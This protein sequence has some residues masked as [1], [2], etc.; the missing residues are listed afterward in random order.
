MASPIRDS[1]QAAQIIIDSAERFIR[2]VGPEHQRQIEDTDVKDVV[3]ALVVVQQDLL[4]RRANRN[5]RKLHPFIQAL[6]HYS[7]ALDVL[8][9]G[10]SPFMPFIYAPIKLMLQIGSDYLAAFDK[11]LEAY[12]RIAATLPR[13]KDLGE[14]F[15]DS[16]TLLP[17]LA[18]YYA[19]V[20]EFHRRAYK[21]VTRKSWTFF[22]MTTWASFH[23]RFESILASMARNSDSIHQEAIVIDLIQSKKSRE[24]IFD[25]VTSQERERINK[26]RDS[27][28][29]WLGVQSPS[30]CIH[31]E[32]VLRDYLPGSCDW[33]IKHAKVIPW[34]QM[35]PKSPVLWIH[36]KP[37]AGKTVICA[38]IIEHLQA[39]GNRM[40]TV[41]YFC[42]YN[43]VDTSSEILKA[44]V[45]QLMKANPDMAAVIYDSYVQK[46]R[47]PSTRVLKMML[48]GAPDHPGL[49]S[50]ASPCRIII[51]GVDECASQEQKFIIQDMLQLVSVDSSQ[52][53]KVLVCSRDIPEIA[54]IM[55]NGAKKLATISL[56]DESDAISHTIESFA[57]PKLQ[58]LV[59]ERQTWQLSEEENS[60]L[61]K[62]VASR[63]GGMM[64]W[65]RLV[66]ESL[67]EVDTLRE[68]HD[69]IKTMPREL[70]DLYDKILTSIAEQ[71]GKRVADRILRILGWLVYAKRPLKAHEILHG[72]ALTV[73]SPVLGTWDMLDD[74]AVERCK[75]LIELLPDGSIGLI[76][77]TTE[78]YLRKRL[79]LDPTNGQVLNRSIALSCLLAL[80][81]GLD[82][83]DP[84]IPEEHRLHSVVSGSNAFLLYAVDFWL[85]HLLA[86]EYTTHIRASD[87]V[88]IVLARL[89][90]KHRS[91]WT[92][93]RSGTE[94]TM[95]PS[96]ASAVEPCLMVVSNTL[97]FPLCASFHEFRVRI[98]K[99]RASNGE[100]FEQL[101]LKEDSTLFTSLATTFSSLVARL[102]EGVLL[103]NVSPAQYAR[104]LKQYSQCSY[105]C[106]FSPCTRALA[107][108]PSEALRTTH[109]ELHARQLFCVHQNCA[110]GRIGF[111]NQR[112]LDA[113]TKKYHE[114]GGI[115]VP[116]RVRKAPSDI[117]RTTPRKTDLNPMPTSSITKV[118]VV[119][120]NPKCQEIITPFGE[121]T[122]NQVLESIQQASSGSVDSAVIYNADML[123]VGTFDHMLTFKWDAVIFAV[124]ISP[125]VSV[126]AFGSKNT[127][128]IFDFNTGEI[129]YR[130]SLDADDGRDNYV[131]SVK[132]SPDG[133]LLAFAG[134]DGSQVRAWDYGS[135]TVKTGSGHKGDILGLCYAPNGQFIATASG[136][137]TLRL[138]REEPHNATLTLQWTIT[139]LAGLTCV[140]VSPDSE[141][142]IVGGFDKQCRVYNAQTG[143]LEFCTPPAHGSIYGVAVSMNRKLLAT[144]SLDSKVYLFEPELNW[145]SL[146]SSTQPGIPNMKSLEYHV[147]SYI[148]L[149]PIHRMLPLIARQR[150]LYRIPCLILYLIKMIDGYSP[151]GATGL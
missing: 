34:V 37:G 79:Q 98:K 101:A 40:T 110:R 68:L 105:P 3:D 12:D 90:Q 125:D 16:P 4:R 62:K 9:N 72:V 24:Q 100:E 135:D 147:A 120:S 95:T 21:F 53:C 73:E 92:K 124:D 54:R 74:S 13:I 39:F 10:L 118:P 44:F 5:L 149:L 36:G 102:V 88:G 97:A 131:M 14:A 142:V 20:L 6:G 18:L 26:Q 2:T 126:V 56:S 144:S 45:L 106:R 111:Q 103:D 1:A 112:G 60:A 99:G 57:K 89:D 109:E 15:K 55:Q 22:F 139:E 35:Q 132:F 117:G 28:I 93:V 85:E 114:E 33:A 52:N 58:E 81:N 134:E 64:L 136:D 43:Q 108:F 75:P 46:H 47:E 107:G 51:D 11:L 41:Y 127:V 115:L 69:A 27:V 146:E 8:S 71:K 116:P 77:F 123:R 63:A 104:F 65:V 148:T 42:R 113:H 121:T 140:T 143:A 66:L 122:S 129:R 130:Y 91:I 87:P 61:C 19:D 78:E 30:Q 70:S 137:R 23:T 38:S 133:K 76:H 32:Q 128:A 31:L 7:G 141:H 119:V 150:L 84:T 151:A 50:A 82:L 94:W 59:R 145:K 80:C 48:S 25:Q 67:S 96:S 49:L 138:W 86:N 29:A 17:K 83:L